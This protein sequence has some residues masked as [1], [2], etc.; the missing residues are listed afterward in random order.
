MSHPVL[1]IEGIGDTI[2][3]VADDISSTLQTIQQQKEQQQTDALKA[4]LTQAQIQNTTAETGERQANTAEARARTRELEKK[5]Q[6]Q[7]MDQDEF[8]RAMGPVLAAFTRT[9]GQVGSEDFQ[10]AIGQ[11]V[12]SVRRP[13]AG[14]LLHTRLSQF[15]SDVTEAPKAVATLQEQVARG[16]KAVTDAATAAAE[17]PSKTAA[18][19]ALD[20]WYRQHPDTPLQ[21]GLEN[22][23]ASL[24]RQT[25][26]VTADRQGEIAQR[27]AVLGALQ[28]A[29]SDF[30]REQGDVT[31][32]A[33]GKHPLSYFVAQQADALQMKPEELIARAHKLAVNMPDI[34]QPSGNRGQDI[35]TVRQLRIRLQRAGLDEEGQASTLVQSGYPR[36][37]LEGAGFRN[38]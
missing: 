26:Q 27:M 23:R 18:A 15:V 9:G 24:E 4:L 22:L 29:R 19:H 28:A 38:R 16:Q 17:A 14:T 12:A 11:A 6:D 1:Q 10:R 20:S 31:V 36:E 2:G 13:G 32:P 21:I 34:P 35:R 25:Q 5:Q 33:A 7:Q 37:V 3:K 8:E 30:R